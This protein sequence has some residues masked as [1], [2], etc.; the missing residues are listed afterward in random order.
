MQW[1]DPPLPVTR[2]A[3]LPWTLPAENPP[4]AAPAGVAEV[5]PAT[6]TSDWAPGPP[7]PAAPS[8]SLALL[9]PLL[10][11]ESRAATAVLPDAD[12]MPVATV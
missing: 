9:G 7:S 2:T 1:A 11:S 10:L 4:A 3:P 5:L 6:S 8:S 12:V